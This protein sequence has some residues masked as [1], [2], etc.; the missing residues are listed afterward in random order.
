MLL[1]GTRAFASAATTEPF[2]ITPEELVK[3][4]LEVDALKTISD[5]QLTTVQLTHLREM[6]EN[7]AGD[8]PSA[9]DHVDP[10]Y[11]AA[12]N[13]LHDA[14]LSGDKEKIETAKGRVFNLE[15]KLGIDPPSPDVTDAAFK[16]ANEVMRLLTP[17]Q[18][19]GYIARNADDMVDCGTLLGD[20]VDKSHDLP[21]DKFISLRDRVAGEISALLDF[22]PPD[23]PKPPIYQKIVK[24]LDHVHGMS[25]DSLQSQ[26][27]ALDDNISDIL[28]KIG[29]LQ[30]L[31][32]WMDHRMAL[33]LANPEVHH[34]IDEYKKAI[35]PN[36]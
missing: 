10:D 13:A 15:A 11:D 17:H 28:N 31:K 23:S 35:A 1:F 14:I 33:L 32:N 34:A 4:Q 9:P 29:P 30:G 21:K 25:H 8:L 22:T 12:L 27:I 19:V 16:R 5:M 20:A 3:T 2:V 24:L 6:T 26:R 36:Q 7:P 18:F